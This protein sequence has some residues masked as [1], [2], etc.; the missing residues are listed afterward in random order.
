MVVGVI[1]FDC[2]IKGIRFHQRF[3]DYFIYFH[4]CK[5]VEKVLVWKSSSLNKERNITT[6]SVV[7]VWFIHFSAYFYHLVRYTI[8]YH[9][10]TY[11]T[12][13]FF[14][15]WH[16]LWCKMVSTNVQAKLAASTSASITEAI[17]FSSI[18]S[19]S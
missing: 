6:K 18:N 16:S 12:L 5:N 4:N 8:I 3:H 2:A 13:K 1:G 15:V 7:S 19:V 17:T 10:A 14:L 11:Q 9:F